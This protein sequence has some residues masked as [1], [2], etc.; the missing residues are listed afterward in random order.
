MTFAVRCW[1]NIVVAWSRIVLRS[2][3][4]TLGSSLEWSGLIA[5]GVTETLLPYDPPAQHTTGGGKT[6]RRA[7]RCVYK[8]I[9][10]SRRH[11]TCPC[12]WLRSICH[13]LACFVMSPLC[14]NLQYANDTSQHGDANAGITGHVDP[15][16]SKHLL[17]VMVE[18]SFQRLPALSRC[19]NA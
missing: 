12:T 11:I 7:I 8:P 15:A 4:Y 2:R 1:F 3:V 17:Q 16:A 6:I 10:Q 5:R 9:W 13:C 19:G 14:S 18:T